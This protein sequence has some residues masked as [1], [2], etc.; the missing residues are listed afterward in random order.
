VLG[1]R[2][3]VGAAAPREVILGRVGQALGLRAFEGHHHEPLVLP[4]PEPRQPARELGR[5]ERSAGQRV[6]EV[7]L[8]PAFG[9]GDRARLRE[10]DREQRERV[11]RHDAVDL[12][13]RVGLAH[14]QERLHAPLRADWLDPHVIASVHERQ[15]EARPV[16]T[17]RADLLPH[18]RGSGVR[19]CGGR[20]ERDAV[21]VQQER[22]SADHAGQRD[23]DA[24]DAT[25]LH[26]RAR[27]DVLGVHR[28]LEHVE[29]LR[30]QPREHRL[31]DRDERHRVGHLEQRE[32]RLLGRPDERLRHALV[33]EAQAESEAG[34]S[35]LGQALEVGALLARRR[36]DP[37]ARR[38]EDLAALQ[39]RG[40]VL[41]LGAVDPADGAVHARLAGDQTKGEPRDG[42]DLSDGQGHPRI[43][44][45]VQKPCLR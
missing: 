42:E 45:T 11:A 10:L 19:R 28:A 12:R 35:L 36:P 38:E 44:R 3:Q 41:E 30:E 16:G 2:D 13:Q 32:P 43:V 27:E 1:A 18:A 9:L 4:E 40:R 17:G 5:H 26:H 7:S 24:V 37:G 20:R 33:P 15:A 25:A 31:G 34:Q 22:P 23:G 14:G 39:P 29:L 21:Q 6:E 8:E